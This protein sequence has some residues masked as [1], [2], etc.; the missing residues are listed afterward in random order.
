MTITFSVENQIIKRTDCR[1]V[2]A[3]S[4]NYLRA[5]FSFTND[6]SGIITAF[7]THGDDTYAMIL[8]EDN[9]CLVPWEVIKADGF[10]V[11][12]VCGSR[13]TANTASV[14]VQESGYRE[15]KTPQEPT[16]DVYEQLLA[17]LQAKLD[18]NQGRENA[19]KFLKIGQNGDVVPGEGS[20]ASVDFDETIT[21]D[22]TTGK[23]GIDFADISSAGYSEGKA[24][25][26]AQ[27]NELLRNLVA[28]INKKQ[29]V[30]TAGQG[31]KIVDN[32]ISA[33]QSKKEIPLT[34][35]GYT[36]IEDLERGW[37]YVTHP[38]KL[39]VRGG[40][41]RKSVFLQEG[42]VF[43]L[44]VNTTD[45][46]LMTGTNQGIPFYVD[47]TMD[48]WL[49]GNC[50]TRDIINTLLSNYL[51]TTEV[52][53]ALE[54]KQ[55]VRTEVNITDNT[56]TALTIAK[57]TDYVFKTL[58]GTMALSLASAFN[59]GRSTLTFTTGDTPNVTLDSDDMPEKW[60]GEEITTFEAN[61]TYELDFRVVTLPVY[62]SVNDE[63]VQTPTLIIAG[64]AVTEA[65]E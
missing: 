14:Y 15:G 13:L 44:M 6:W 32:V 61:T 21:Q 1:Q 16:P 28:L 19:G 42:D 9:T 35:A 8:D 18:A 48:R 4:Q 51:T 47:Y 31:I 12:C 3:D 55:D 57:D 52:N 65:S 27:A 23:Y 7:F 17:R 50:V 63:V 22:E 59:S 56:L 43:Y 25:S 37:H 40:G 60:H 29:D 5:S 33:T 36:Y 64:G 46:Y 20:S 11:S 39:S 58:V 45:G 30:L 49:D 54:S 53:T 34:S 2:V 62:D 24:I 26:G 38:G 10:T 41:S